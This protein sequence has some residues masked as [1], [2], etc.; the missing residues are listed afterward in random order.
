MPVVSRSGNLGDFLEYDETRE[1][2]L[3][4]AAADGTL[5]A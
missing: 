5:Q 3:G 4:L 2:L 1:R